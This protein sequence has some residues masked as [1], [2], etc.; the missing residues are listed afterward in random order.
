MRALI[1]IGTL[2]GVIVYGGT[3]YILTHAIALSSGVDNAIWIVAVALSLWN[4]IVGLVGIAAV[5][6]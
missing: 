2:I 5:T 1:L 6:D 3:A 4:L